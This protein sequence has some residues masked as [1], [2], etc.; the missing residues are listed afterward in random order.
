MGTCDNIYV[1]NTLIT[2][3]INT[4]KKVMLCI[5]RLLQSN[6]LSCPQNI[7][8]KLIRLG[9][10]GKMFWVIQSMYESV[11]SRVNMQNRVGNVND[12]EDE[13]CT[14]GNRNRYNFDE[15]VSINECRRHHYHGRN[16]WRSSVIIEQYCNKWKL[17][18]DKNKTK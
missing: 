2:H 9:I 1:L 7:W 14:K 18:L 11:K 17:K 10:R 4:D 3:F 8:C 13:L 16:A 12:L 6:W 5:Y 15:N